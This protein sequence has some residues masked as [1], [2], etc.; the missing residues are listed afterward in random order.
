MT[1]AAAGTY[2]VS[3]S[4]LLGGLTS[5]PA[6][7]TVLLP[8]SI[9]SEP[10]DFV[11]TNGSSAS[12]TVA[13]TG[14][15][16]LTYQWFFNQTNQLAGATGTNLDLT[17][18]TPA[19]AG[20]YSVV[21]SNQV[22]TLRSR[23]AL[24]TILTAPIIVQDPLDQVAT[25]GDTVTFTV[26]AGGS[27]PLEYQWYFRPASES[28]DASAPAPD[29]W[30]DPTNRI[31]DATN[32]SLVL[33]NVPV[34][35]SG[36]YLVAVDNVLGTA[37]SLPA[38]LSV[39]SPIQILS[40]PQNVAVL[41]GGT[42]QFSVV[43]S[44]LPEPSYQWVFN[45][46]NIISG[47]N[48]NRLVISNVQPIQ[49][50]GYF[51]VVSNSIHVVTSSVAVLI[52]ADPPAIVTQPL[53]VTIAAG[54]TAS[55]NVAATGTAPLRFAW[56]LNETNLAAVTS[57]GQLLITNVTFQQSGSYRAVVSNAV[58]SATSQSASLRVLVP[59]RIAAIDNAD[60]VLTLTFGTLSG[61]RY[62]VEYTTNLTG[63]VW[64][65]VTSAEKVIG[66]GNPLTIQDPDP[67][68]NKRYYRIRVE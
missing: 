43:A 59:P 37:T 55:F 26:L 34:Q 49:Q 57:G 54:G 15:E 64:T 38:T 66:T 21:V 50:G 61:L 40:Q 28:A 9:A 44:G 53:N 58:G 56:F 62:T 60:G 12:F 39:M 24:L 47:A 13:A 7:L 31:I 18:L 46:T 22:G 4:N 16:P 29:W 65:R 30:L 52:I 41:L 11:A 36:A 51:V 14:T 1:A 19:Q 68:A 27:A 5:Q 25:N 20:H 17:A 63:G 42:A 45:Q 3:V 33:S 23:E 35:A 6:T 32:S 10:S 2:T 67:V 48:S 8:P